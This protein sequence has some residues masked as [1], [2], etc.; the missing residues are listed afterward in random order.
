MKILFVF[1][2]IA[3]SVGLYSFMEQRPIEKSNEVV[4][5]FYKLAVN[6]DR[7]DTDD[8]ISITENEYNSTTGCSG[9]GDVCRLKLSTAMPANEN[10]VDTDFDNIPDELEDL[11]PIDEIK[12]RSE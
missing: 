8:Y 10:L 12:E 2:L 9:S 6:G 7:F 4:E 11:T 1:A 5:H 3:L